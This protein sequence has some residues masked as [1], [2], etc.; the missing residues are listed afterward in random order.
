MFIQVEKTEQ[1]LF[2]DFVKSFAN[3]LNDFYNG[4]NS[5]HKNVF[6]QF[7]NSQYDPQMIAD[8][9]GFEKCLMLFKLSSAV[10]EILKADLNYVELV[11]EKN[12]D[13]ST[14]KIIITDKTVV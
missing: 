3:S 13:F 2:T 4:I 7:W 5:S 10:Q 6:N 1:E 11:P 8:A 12:V 14:G 9:L